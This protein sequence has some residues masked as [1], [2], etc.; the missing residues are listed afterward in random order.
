[1][2]IPNP[3]PVLVQ[4]EQLRRAIAALEERLTALERQ[5]GK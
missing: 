3:T 1:M 4:L 5:R 2:T